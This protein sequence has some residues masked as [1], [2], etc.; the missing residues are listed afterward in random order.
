MSRDSGTEDN[1]YE[2]ST[3]SHHAY[4]STSMDNMMEHYTNNGSTCLGDMECYNNNDSPSMGD[5]KNDNDKLLKSHRPRRSLQLELRSTIKW[6]S[7]RATSTTSRR[8]WTM[9]STKT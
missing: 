5:F 1:F 6:K 3:M 2:E 4:V 8:T 9:T 7:S